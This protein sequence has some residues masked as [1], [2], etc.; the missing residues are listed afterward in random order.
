MGYR[1]GTPATKRCLSDSYLITAG[2]AGRIMW[3]SS[4]K[5]GKGRPGMQ[6]MKETVRVLA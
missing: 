5:E 4:V 6:M 3:T 2:I 1:K